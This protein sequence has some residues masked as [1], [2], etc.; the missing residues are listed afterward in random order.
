M[1]EISKEDLSVISQKLDKIIKL[2][3]MNT[4]KDIETD[5]GK[6]ELLEQLGFRPVEIAFCLGKTPDNINVQLSFIRKKR[7][8]QSPNKNN[9]EEKNQKSLDKIIESNEKTK[10]EM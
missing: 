1:V 9:S 7:A 8:K 10:G 5:Q 2:L 4:V 6:I 3:A